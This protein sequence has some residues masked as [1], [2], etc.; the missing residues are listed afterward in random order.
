[1]NYDIQICSIS[2]YERF[3]YGIYR[4]GHFILTTDLIECPL[5][6]LHNPSDGALSH[7][8]P[9]EPVTQSIRWGTYLK[10][11]PTMAKSSLISDSLSKQQAQ[12]R[13]GRESP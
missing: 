2:I 13:Q 6:Q 1:M 4:I 12:T 9:S 10:S 11:G 8:R 7:L 3:K 5:N